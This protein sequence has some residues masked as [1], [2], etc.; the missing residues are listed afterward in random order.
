MWKIE[1]VFYYTDAVRLKSNMIRIKYF[2]EPE[3]PHRNHP[4]LTEWPSANAAL[5]NSDCP[6]N[7][8]AQLWIMHLEDSSIAQF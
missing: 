4:L 3:H 1:L 5:Q 6:S 7:F 8:C 2:F